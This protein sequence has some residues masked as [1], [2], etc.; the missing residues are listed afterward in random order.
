MY[1][2]YF[3]KLLPLVS[4]LFLQTFVYAAE[5]IPG[6]GTAK[7]RIDKLVDSGKASQAAVVEDEFIINHSNP[8]DRPKIIS[9]MAD[10]RAKLPCHDYGRAKALYNRLIQQH[11]DDNYA[12]RA[13]LKIPEID[14]FSKIET[15]KLGS[16]S[17][18]IEQMIT[19]DPNNP[20]LPETL[21]DIAVRYTK[22]YYFEQADTLY[23]RL[24]ENYPS[25]SCAEKA[26]FERIKN[27]LFSKFKKG[28][29]I[30][31]ILSDTAAQY[32]NHEHLPG[33]LYFSADKYEEN[34][35]YDKAKA[36]YNQTIATDPNSSYGQKSILE[37]KKIDIYEKISSGDFTSAHNLTEQL[38]AG[39]QTH[40]YL[41]E[42][43]YNIADYYR[44]CRNHERARQV[45]SRLI[46][47]FPN[48]RF[49]ARGQIE[50][51]LL[52]I[53]AKMAMGTFDPAAGE[54]EQLKSTRQNDYLLSRRCYEL[55]EYCL[56]NYNYEAAISVFQVVRQQFP[57]YSY[58][59]GRAKLG[60][61]TAKICQ[62]IS[63]G[64]L[65]DA[66]A[67]IAQLKRDYA[68]YYYMPGQLYFIARAYLY[69]GHQDMSR[70]L[71]DEVINM[72]QGKYAVHSEMFKYH[73]DIRSHLQAN[74]L[75]GAKQILDEF[76]S[77]YADSLYLEEAILDLA[78]EFCDMGCR[79]E[80]SNSN[81]YLEEAVAIC[82]EYEPV[83]ANFKIRFLSVL[84]QSQYRLGNFAESASCYQKIA[85]TYPD[86]CLVWSAQF[87]AG[88]AY[89]DMLNAGGISEQQANTK[90]KAAY[91]KLLEKYP[92]CA[93]A[94]LAGTWLKNHN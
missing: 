29:P 87:M 23:Q 5:D 82:R 25:E 15:G 42:V 28:E 49:S 26:K 12:K 50:T 65:A 93:V 6:L 36:L 55:G 80:D 14:I 89:E 46:G 63:N 85:D 91:Q 83:D 51:A 70:A 66:Q 61:D 33:V 60:Y 35:R 76:K 41:P 32:P 45:Y 58:Y 40:Y 22:R 64:N 53:R 16:A 4:L 3:F 37:L 57:E 74:D 90:I 17:V 72:G 77:K 7:K 79:N 11:P 59:Y 47:L 39:H 38:I 44:K 48:D 34:Y 30:E 24:I 52:D 54:I 19:N 84:A 62:K 94:E 9:D 18:D 68:G 78:G 75:T 31:S 2:R 21:Y 73:L 88:R 10:S 69:Y 43:L 67:D 8:S 27:T 20:Y 1:K 92:D 13:S 86:S 56:Y 81:T 71:C